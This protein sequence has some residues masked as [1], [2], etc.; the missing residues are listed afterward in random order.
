M[1]TPVLRTLLLSALLVAAAS[2]VSV[3]RAEGTPELPQPAPPTCPVD[4]GGPS[5]V[6]IVIVVVQNLLVVYP[7]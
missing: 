6:D 3:A 2:P 4:N 5:V 1:R 7:I